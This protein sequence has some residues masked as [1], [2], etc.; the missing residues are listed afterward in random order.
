MIA[1]LKSLIEVR[2]EI[3]DLYYSD[4][5]AWNDITPKHSVM[6]DRWSN[7][8]WS[9]ER[10]TRLL[11]DYS[12]IYKGD[13]VDINYAE[14]RSIKRLYK[15]IR[16]EKNDEKQARIWSEIKDNGRYGQ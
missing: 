2:P 3:Q 13:L 7:G 9:I 5:C 4:S 15:R 10:D 6:R 8:L 14:Y 16:K 12:L 11:T 1:W